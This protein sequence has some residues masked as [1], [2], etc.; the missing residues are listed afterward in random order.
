MDEDEEE[1]LRKR[2]KTL[3]EIEQ[4]NGGPGVYQFNLREH[5]ILENPMWKNDE[6]PEF[7]MG[8]NVHDFYHPNIGEELKALEE[9]EQEIEEMLGD[10]DS[11][12]EVPL[13]DGLR[14]LTNDQK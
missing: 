11:E 7:Y 8:K 6:I 2:K 9:E 3:K 1:P 5:C 14:P 10:S 13:P 12:A 4:E